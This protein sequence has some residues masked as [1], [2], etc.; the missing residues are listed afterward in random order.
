MNK[1]SIN[2]NNTVKSSLSITQWNCNH[3]ISK[4]QLFK[5]FLSLHSPDI[6]L[7]NE[8]K[9][10]IEESNYYLN[11]TNYAVVSKV[12]NA[13][14]GGVA[15][16]IKNN[17]TFN[18]DFSYEKYNRELICINIKLNDKTVSIFSLY[19]PPYNN[20]NNNYLCLDLFDEINKKC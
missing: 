4:L 6:V 13:F 18:Q 19:N 14:G 8:I 16:L 12:R 7:L 11:F 2:N 5:N 20:K 1:S 9:T 17:I 15:I 10:S 3:I